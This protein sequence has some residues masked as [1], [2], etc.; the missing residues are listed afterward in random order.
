[1][2][3]AFA[4]FLFLVAF[5]SVQPSF[6]QTYNPCVV[7]GSFLNYDGTPLARHPFV[8][9]KVI[10]DSLFFVNLPR[11]VLTDNSGVLRITLPQGGEVLIFSN[12]SGFNSSTG[13]RLFIPYQDTA[14]IFSCL[15][16]SVLERNIL[17]V[18][19]SGFDS[20]LYYKGRFVETSGDNII[21]GTKNF[22]GTTNFSGPINLNWT[23]SLES[24]FNLYFGDYS[25]I[26]GESSG[27][28]SF[29]NS[30]SGSTGVL[31]LELLN[32]GFFYVKTN[33][34]FSFISKNGKSLLG[35]PASLS[36]GDSLLHVLGGAYFSGGLLSEGKIHS[37]STF[38]AE[39]S[40]SLSV[41]TLGFVNTRVNRISPDHPS[42]DTWV[43]H[44]GENTTK[45]AA[46]PAF[47]KWEFDTS[48]YS[49]G[50]FDFV[51]FKTIICE[52]TSI[53]GMPLPRLV[54]DT[55]LYVSQEDSTIAEL[56]V[57]EE[58]AYRIYFQGK[59]IPSSN[60]IKTDSLLYVE[61]NFSD[62]N[63]DFSV[64]SNDNFSFSGTPKAIRFSG[65][66]ENLFFNRFSGTLSA[67]PAF[68]TDLRNFS[69]FDSEF[70]L[71]RASNIGLKS[72]TFT[73]SSILDA[74][75]HGMDA[76]NLTF[77][78]CKLNNAD[79]TNS[80]LTSFAF[81]NSQAFNV[82]FSQCYLGKDADIS[83]SSFDKCHFVG[84][85]PNGMRRVI[86]GIMILDSLEAKDISMT[87]CLL[88]GSS[89]IGAN[90]YQDG[91]SGS[92]FEHC[93]FSNI[94]KES[95]GVYD[96]TSTNWTDVEASNVVI[97]NSKCVRMNFTNAQLNSGK[98]TFNDFTNAIWNGAKVNHTNFT[99]CIGM[100]D[101]AT[102]KA[103]VNTY[104]PTT[105]IWVDGLPI[106]S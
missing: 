11:E 41:T 32:D 44:P 66:C 43:L 6:G 98:L 24:G 38:L 72:S 75:L 77:N 21:N 51:P 103:L 85:T 46:D 26:V 18:I 16:D 39:A 81:R 35:N 25:R 4:I 94:I 12:I 23:T 15:I 102:F 87:D 5:F 68:T 8:I 65:N 33:D 63:F 1:M 95:P 96:T 37:S 47:W 34:K 106:G 80:N 62:P 13:A 73:R 14:Q 22:L 78:Y 36:V 7:T 50:Y 45:F 99:G 42:Y 70:R 56:Y 93:R 67:S 64:F 74:F 90:F 100:P 92:R 69:A 101:K 76:P 17:P 28:T 91:G 55:T 89:W 58:T 86:D 30:A 20:T 97:T 104:N 29:I 52:G 82:R 53:W 31:N 10:K 57:V 48:Y 83:F 59:P 3:R 61:L 60:Y 79:F 2:H 19:I 54:K 84:E 49:V 40:D 27:R 88:Y 71:V 9:R 105:T